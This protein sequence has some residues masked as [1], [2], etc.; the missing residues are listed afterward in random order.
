MYR[1]KIGDLI[2][3]L[4]VV[5]EIASA[6]DKIYLRDLVS[7]YAVQYA[8]EYEF[9]ID[10]DVYELVFNQKFEQKVALAIGSLIILTV[11]LH[12][13]SEQLLLN[14]TKSNEKMSV[15]GFSYEYTQSANL[16][17]QSYKQL[18]EIRDDLEKRLKS[19]LSGAAFNSLDLDPNL[20]PPISYGS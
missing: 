14:K 10:F 18:K 19:Y 3:R 16:L 7:E 2:D 6:K 15:D 4:V 12:L 5:S 9:E 17:N 13:L 1:I 11:S 20:V 8:F